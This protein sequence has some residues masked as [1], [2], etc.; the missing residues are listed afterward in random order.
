VVAVLL[1]VWGTGYVELRER[2]RRRV[3]TPPHPLDSGYSQTGISV[4]DL[5]HLPRPDRVGYGPPVAFPSVPEAGESGRSLPRANL[6]G[7]DSFEPTAAG[8]ESSSPSPVAAAS[9]PEQLQQWE[10]GHPRDETDSPDDQPDHSPPFRAGDEA[11]SRS[12]APHGAPSGRASTPSPDPIRRESTAST[13]NGSGNTSATSSQCGEDLGDTAASPPR[14]SADAG[15]PMEPVSPIRDDQGT[16]DRMSS[17]DAENHSQTSRQ[18]SGNILGAPQY[19]NLEATTSVT[20]EAAEASEVSRHHAEVAVDSA[21]TQNGHPGSAAST[22]QLAAGAG[23]TTGKAAAASPPVASPPPIVE[24][25]KHHRRRKRKGK[26]AAAT[27]G[28]G[29]LDALNKLVSRPPSKVLRR[30][31]S[32]PALPS[33]SSNVE[34]H[35]KSE[36]SAGAHTGSSAALLQEMLAG[37]KRRRRKKKKRVRK[38]AT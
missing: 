10:A 33:S 13:P 16:A 9:E 8:T 1:L 22:S 36:N 27:A 38:G 6:T 7:V 28:L 20:A 11:S 19:P 17:A 15:D 30:P 25:R 32:M 21:Q 34:D 31:E 2:K 18:A 4:E 23:S 12:L 14:L 37:S 29:D 26:S 3:H 35:K 24:A 5:S